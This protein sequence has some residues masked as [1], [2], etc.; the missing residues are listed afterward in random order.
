MPVPTRT[1]SCSSLAEIGLRGERIAFVG[2]LSGMTRAE[3]RGLVVQHG[4]EI[5]DDDTTIPTLAVIGDSQEDL[6][7]ALGSDKAASRRLAEDIEAGRTQLIHESELW[8]RVGLVGEDAAL[9]RGVQRLYTPAML[10]ELLGVPIGAVRRWHRQGALVACRSVRRLAYFDFAEVAVARH[11][12]TLYSAGC[13]LQVI[14]RKLAELKRF[15]PDVA[16]P[17]SDRSI[18]VSGR[19]VYLR[20]GD[21]LTEPGGQLLIDF[22]K[23]LDQVAD[24]D[25]AASQVV[26]PLS[27]V[28]SV[29]G[30][31][32]EHADRATYSGQMDSGGHFSTMDELQQSALEWEDLGELERA[33]EVYRTMLVAGG[34]SAELHFA[35]GDLLYRLGDLSA[36]RERYYAAIELDEEYVEARANLGCVFAEKGELEL[37]V[38]AF[39]GA[40]AFHPD[41]ADAHYHLATTHDR[42]H[43][44]S[45]A[46]LHWHTF[47]ALAPESPWAEMARARLGQTQ[48]EAPA[49][50]DL[51]S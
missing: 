15:L 32:A 44:G 24:D 27:S 5:V 38:A 41:Y 21:D 36:A 1:P 35:L 39:E 6:A 12:A 46:E 18:I 20:R 23:P 13:S 30:A 33:A 19:R 16:R 7:S 25:A 50:S 51:L 48:S 3:A 17:L 42:L 14:D 34:P 31:S 49:S 47:L 9:D 22:D 10:A 43:C 29:P 28:G 11:L 45:E 26:L 2:R 8:Q 4:G 37:A 40:L